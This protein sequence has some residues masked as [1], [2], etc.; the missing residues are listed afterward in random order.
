M[1]QIK[2]TEHNWA[3]CADLKLMI[4]RNI[5]VLLAYVTAELEFSTTKRF[6]FEGDLHLG[7]AEYDKY[8]TRGKRPYN[9][10]PFRCSI[11]AHATVYKTS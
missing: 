3:V 4:I 5:S 9:I 2:Y 7:E 10:A 6:A 8:T 11:G 1:E